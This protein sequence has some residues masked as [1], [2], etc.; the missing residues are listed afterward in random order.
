MANDAALRPVVA[1]ILR[2]ASS[3]LALSL[4]RKY[5]TRFNVHQLLFSFASLTLSL[6]LLQSNYFDVR[7]SG[8]RS[9]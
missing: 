4:S 1:A 3:V 8:E 7:H 2:G 6:R 5:E 9:R